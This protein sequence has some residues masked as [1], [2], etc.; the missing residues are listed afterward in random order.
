MTKN[1]QHQLVQDFF[2]QQ[3]QTIGHTPQ[4]FDVLLE[5]S[6]KRAKHVM[7]IPQTTLN[8]I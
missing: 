4:V 8:L 6:R 3:Y 7:Y 5:E 2:H 1:Y